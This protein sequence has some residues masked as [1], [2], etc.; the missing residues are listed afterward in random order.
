ME[1]LKSIEVFAPGSVSNMGSG[2]D[3][4]GFPLEAVGDTLRVGLNDSG[5]VT[6]GRITGYSQ[7]IPTEPEKNV[8]SYAVMKMLEDFGTAQGV[9]I[10]IDKQIMAGSGIGSSAASSAGAVVA[11]NELLDRP[12]SVTQLIRFAMQGEAL[13]S[14]GE[15][16]DNVAPVIGGGITV[17]RSYN[18]LD[19][20][21][22]PPPEDMWVVIL[23]PQIEVRTSVGRGVLPKSLPL[24]TA[25]KQWGNVAGLIAGLYTHDFGLMGRAMEDVVAEPKRAG[26][27]PG[28]YDAKAVALAHGA[29][30]VSISGSGPSVFALCKGREAAENVRLALSAKYPEAGIPFK[31]YKSRVNATGVKVI[32]G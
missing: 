16:A 2:F 24:Q 10:A 8:A 27:I 31:I 29:S 28:Y 18:P 5:K 22:I 13:I 23:H 15:H 20:I 21:T 11:V 14:G 12:Y 26:L 25:V 3:I 7:G 19:I 32:S 6:L 1:T 17:I 30:G 9:D 4:I